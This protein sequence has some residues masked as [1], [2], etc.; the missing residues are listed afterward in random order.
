MPLTIFAFFLIIVGSANLIANRAARKDKEKRAS[1]FEKEGQANT[2]PKQ[3]ISN[4]SYIDLSSALLP[5]DVCKDK[6]V[7]SEETKVR[8]LQTEKIVNL[9]NYTNTE[10]KLQYGVANLAMLTQ[11]DDNYATLCKSLLA[12]GQALLE[13]G[14]PKEAV[15]VLEYGVSIGSD[16]TGNYITLA[17]LYRDLGV[18]YK[19]DQL[20][21]SAKK[22]ES[23]SK[24][25]IILKLKDFVHP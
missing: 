24:D 21:D 4:L 7:L 5:Y 17:Y 25:N 20:L 3:D 8:S 2:T 9:S 13:A 16:I 6:A 1:F 22:L 11:Y 18:S 10:L 12:W 15:T 14:Y 23:L 19:I